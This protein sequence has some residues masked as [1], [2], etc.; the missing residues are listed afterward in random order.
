MITNELIVAYLIFV[1][2]CC[3]FLF[4]R[5]LLAKR[6]EWIE[7]EESMTAEISRLKADMDI[8]NERLKKAMEKI[9][10]LKKPLEIDIFSVADNIFSSFDTPKKENSDE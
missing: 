4:S 7:Q 5:Y 9:S 8:L 6:N 1:L 2:F 3:I 10:E